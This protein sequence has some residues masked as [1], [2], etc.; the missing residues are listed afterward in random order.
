MADLKGFAKRMR[1]LG[2]EIEEGADR[3]VINTANA[4]NT[5]VIIATPVDTGRARANWQA[6]VNTAKKNKIDDTDQGGSETMDRNRSV[7]RSRR[8]GESVFLSNNLDYIGR[9]NAGSS[10]QAPAGFVEQAVQAGVVALSRA[11]ILKK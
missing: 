9:L 4:I 6:G 10:A 7:I 11:R 3:Q 2:V 1:Q 8:G 5:T